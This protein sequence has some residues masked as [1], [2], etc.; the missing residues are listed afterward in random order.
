MHGSYHI[1]NEYLAIF[2]LLVALQK[3]SSPLFLFTPHFLGHNIQLFKSIKITKDIISHIL[4]CNNYVIMSMGDSNE[5]YR[6]SKNMRK[7]RY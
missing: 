2:I 3:P 4:K 1:C 5:R 7:K 6:N